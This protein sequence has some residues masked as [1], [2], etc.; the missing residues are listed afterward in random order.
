MKPVEDVGEILVRGGEVPVFDGRVVGARLDGAEFAVQDDAVQHL[1]VPARVR[2]AHDAAG[3]EGRGP[4]AR[5]LVLEQPAR[6]FVGHDAVEGDE[7]SV[8]CLAASLHR[9]ILTCHVLDEPVVLSVSDDDE[10]LLDLRAVEQ[11]DHAGVTV[12]LDDLGAESDGR[13]FSRT[14]CRVRC[15]VF[16]GPMDVDAVVEVPLGAELFFRVTEHRRL[17]HLLERVT[18]GSSDLDVWR[19]AGFLCIKP[20]V[21]QEAGTIWREGDCCSSFIPEL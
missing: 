5:F 17:H 18:L 4:E 9:H 21:I 12:N 7:T 6:R 3:G 20:P 19:A 14:G 8:G 1:V 15:K 2:D 13:R 10:I 16:Q 11:G